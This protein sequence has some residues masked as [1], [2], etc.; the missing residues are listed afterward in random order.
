MWKVRFKTR[1]S[2]TAKVI[3][4]DFIHQEGTSL[5]C[6][7]NSNIRITKEEVTTGFLWW[8]KKKIIEK[9]ERLPETPICLLRPENIL[10]AYWV[11]T[12]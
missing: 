2:K 5:V 12:K 1:D 9:R 10:I 6:L 7:N 8:K 3:N 11:E 4:C